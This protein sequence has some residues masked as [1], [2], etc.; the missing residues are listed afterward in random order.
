LGAGRG[1]LVRQMLTESTVLALGGGLLGLLVAALAKGLLVAF[2]ARFTP[3]ASG[4]GI[5]LRVL[6]FTLALSL[7]TGLAF[8]LLP[9]LHASRRD[10]A[11]ALKESGGQATESRGRHRFR[12]ALV[13]LQVATA[14]VLLV[15]AG[16]TVQSSL[17]LERSDA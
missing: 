8:G 10:L 1:R 5:D 4:V 12:N 3:L 16:L 17:A 14:F 11:A 15:A 6:A 9:A 2:A 7:G 13:V